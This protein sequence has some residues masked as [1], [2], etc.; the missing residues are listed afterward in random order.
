M[1]TKQ[2]RAEARPTSPTYKFQ[3]P[4]HKFLLSIH[5]LQRAL[6]RL[7]SFLSLTHAETPFRRRYRVT[8]QGENRE[9]QRKVS[10]MDFDGN[11]CSGMDAAGAQSRPDRCGAGCA[12]G[13]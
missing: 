7:P 10:T 13:P 3:N 12:Q 1:T 8:I 5:K 11:D 2:R 9:Y 4:A 6:F